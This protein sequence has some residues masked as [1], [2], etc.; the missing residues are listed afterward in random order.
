MF[1]SIQNTIF[2]LAPLSTSGG[3]TVGADKCPSLYLIRGS[4]APK[5]CSHNHASKG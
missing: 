4:V 2:S 3:E 5:K 1:L